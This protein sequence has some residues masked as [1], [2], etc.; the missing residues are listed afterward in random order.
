MHFSCKVP[1]NETWCQTPLKD[2]NIQFILLSVNSKEQKHWVKV[3]ANLISDLSCYF[4]IM[5]YIQS[6]MIFINI[7][8]SHENKTQKNPYI[9]V[10]Y[11]KREKME[12][13]HIIIYLPCL[14]FLPSKNHNMSSQK[15]MDM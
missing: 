13:K 4:N 14:D 10:S 12:K 7:F 8:H 6:K 15:M 1:H 9:Y 3:D 2:D 5:F 11:L